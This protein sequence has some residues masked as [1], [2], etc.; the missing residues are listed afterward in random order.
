MIPPADLLLLRTVFVTLGSLPFQMNLGIAL[1][2]SLKNCVG[3][4]MGIALN[5][6]IAFGRMST[7]TM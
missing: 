3:I 6:L 1:S 7:L 2:M 5:L 4:L